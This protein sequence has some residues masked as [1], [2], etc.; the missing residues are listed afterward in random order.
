MNF[1]VPVVLQCNH[2]QLQCRKKDSRYVKDYEFDLYIDG[3]REMYI[4][5]NYHHISKGALV[6]RKPGQLVESRGDYNMYTLT[7]DF[8]RELNIP[9]YKYLRHRKTEAQK[10]C[11]GD[12]ADI[13]PETFYPKHHEEAI[14]ILKKIANVSYPNIIDE[15]MQEKLVMEFLLM[16]LS[17]A[18]RY[19]RE[20]ESNSNEAGYIEKAC[21]YINRNY[22]KSISIDDISD[23][24]SLNKHYFI[25]IFKKELSTTPNQY[26]KDT[27]LFYAR[28]MLIQTDLTIDEISI[29]C[30]FNTTSYFIK[31]FRGK[32][33]KSPKIYRK[34]YFEEKRKIE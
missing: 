19:N 3:E 24:V 28:L 16:I 12:I 8:S 1:T 13:I 20:C 34:N 30:G 2:F 9:Q 33:G 22:S 17:D 21:K 27:R 31:C 14:Q 5:G 7:L 29:S 32:Y 6:F 4:D 26:I 18:Y 23:Y 11:N 10:F 25:R 15:K